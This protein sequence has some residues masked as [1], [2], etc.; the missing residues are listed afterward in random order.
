MII[1]HERIVYPSYTCAY[2]HS[3]PQVQLVSA[4]SAAMRRRTVTRMQ[5]LEGSVQA[6]QLR[7][8]QLVTELAATCTDWQALVAELECGHQL[9]LGQGLGCSRNGDDVVSGEAPP[10]WKAQ[11]GSDLSVLIHDG[12]G[13]ASGLGHGPRQNDAILIGGSP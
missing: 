2:T 9:A 3:C 13:W 5:T 6:Q 1:S 12:H 7:L 11:L 8:G 10:A 4:L